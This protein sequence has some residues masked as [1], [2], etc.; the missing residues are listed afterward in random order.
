MVYFPLDLSLF[1]S[2]CQEKD[3]L[4]VVNLKSFF[5]LLISFPLFLKYNF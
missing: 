4:T 5:H 3:I 1:S 2:K